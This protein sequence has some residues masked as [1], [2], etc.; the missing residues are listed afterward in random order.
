VD[1]KLFAVLAQSVERIVGGLSVQ[2]LTS[3]SWA[4]ATIKRSDEQLFV[5]L[6]KVAAYRMAKFHAQSLA[7]AA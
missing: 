7:N 4:F 3:I 5:A 1:E 6:A 2:A